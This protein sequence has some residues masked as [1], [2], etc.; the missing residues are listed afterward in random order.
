MSTQHHRVSILFFIYV[1]SAAI[2]GSQWGLLERIEHFDVVFK[3]ERRDW[4]G[5]E[6]HFLVQKQAESAGHYSGYCWDPEKPRQSTVRYDD[7]VGRRGKIEEAWWGRISVAARRARNE[8]QIIVFWKIRIPSRDAIVWYIDDSS[9]FLTGTGFVKDYEQA[10]ACIGTDFWVKDVEY[11]YTM[12]DS[13]VISLK[14]LQ[15]L[16]LD[17]VKW[18]D[19]SNYPL[20][21]ILRTDEEERGYINERT[22][23]S[24]I[25]KWHASDPRTQFPDWEPLTWLAIENR[26]LM[27]GMNPDMVRMAWGDPLAESRIIAPTGVHVF[28]WI[29][30]GIGGRVYGVFFTNARL[31]RWDWHDFKP[32]DPNIVTFRLRKD[33]T[34]VSYQVTI[35]WKRFRMAE[36]DAV[37]FSWSFRH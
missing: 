26:N 35:D 30:A 15:H 5:E 21:F 32:G 23:L 13:S 2:A 3:D 31:Y 18:G 1:T 12:D 19:S 10:K 14:K 29:Y 11:L 27:Q 37:T 36:A 28:L 7:L 20:T 22:A 9:T 8:A 24:L 17:D 25:D 4:I 33:A 16:V 34:V 6:I